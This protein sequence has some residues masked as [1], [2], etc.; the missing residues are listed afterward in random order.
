M[1]LTK[2]R[3]QGNSIIV[4][5][6]ANDKQ[7]LEAQKEYY[8]NFQKNGNIVLIPKIDDPFKPAESGTFYESDEWEDMNAIG[9]EIF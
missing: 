9:E 8:V 3:K 6:P 1:L 5:L 2:T 4:T 7:K